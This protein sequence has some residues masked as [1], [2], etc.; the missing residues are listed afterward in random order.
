MHFR[1]YF[2]DVRDDAR[3]EGLKEGRAEGEALFAGLSAILLEAERYEDL[4]RASSDEEYRRSLY[5]EFGL[6]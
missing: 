4:K 5:E 2:D 1:D 6:A 3:E